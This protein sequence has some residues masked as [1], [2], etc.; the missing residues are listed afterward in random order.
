M[1]GEQCVL[2]VQSYRS[3]HVLDAVR[4]DFD[5]PVLQEGLQSVPMAMDIGQLFAEA[6]LGG[7]A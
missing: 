7:D 6:R 1:S 5:P 4:V 2:P 3:D